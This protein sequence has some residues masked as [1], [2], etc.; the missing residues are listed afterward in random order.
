[1]SPVR[2]SLNLTL[3]TI[4]TLPGPFRKT[5]EHCLAGVGGDPLK[6]VVRRLCRLHFK[7]YFLRFLYAV[8]SAKLSTKL[9]HQ[10]WTTEAFRN[11]FFYDLPCNL[12]IKDRKAFVG[13]LR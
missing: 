13:Y 10:M 12:Y 11:K 9:L 5:L 7:A 3:I 2:P 4:A 6:Q 1:M 8:F